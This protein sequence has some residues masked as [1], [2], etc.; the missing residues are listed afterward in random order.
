MTFHQGNSTWKR[1]HT[2]GKL[3][4]K[5][6]RETKLES[7]VQ[8]LVAFGMQVETVRH[9]ADIESE[10]TIGLVSAGNM[11]QLYEMASSI[12]FVISTIALTDLARRLLN[13]DLFRVMKLS[14]FVNT[15][16][17]GPV[18]N[19]LDLLETQQIREIPGG[20]GLDIY[21]CEPLDPKSTLLTLSNI[22]ATPHFAGTPS[23]R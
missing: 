14:A 19:E 20:A 11:S 1:Q 10:V 12:D 18:I 7:R 4:G 17:Q 23:L 9:N 22:V 21:V 16:S 15:V 6:S 13:Q 3:D 8:E 5:P 2:S